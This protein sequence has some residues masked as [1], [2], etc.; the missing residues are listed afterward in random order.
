MDPVT[1]LRL[2]PESDRYLPGTAHLVRNAHDNHGHSV[3]QISFNTA[4]NTFLESNDGPNRLLILYYSRG[5]L[6]IGQDYV[7]SENQGL[8]REYLL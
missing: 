1:R 7:L 5:G 4:I 3:K 6:V 2:L 8:F